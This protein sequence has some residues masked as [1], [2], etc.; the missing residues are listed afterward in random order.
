MNQELTFEIVP[1]DAGIAPAAKQSL[2]V[3]FSGFFVDAAKLE[4]K[5]A[6]ITDP[7]EARI[8]RLEVKNLRVAVE[9]KHKEIKADALLFGRAVDGAKNIFLA[10][11]QPIERAME[12]IEKAAERAAAEALERVRVERQAKLDE[13]GHDCLGIDLGS[14]TEAQWTAYLQQSK[15]AA[16]ARIEREAK[17]AA[18]LKAA[19]EAEAAAREAQRL[20][21]IRLREEAERREAEIA[22]E[23]AAAEKE[24]KRLEAEATAR[25]NAER[26]EW[27]K[28]EAK[29]KADREAAEEEARKER[30]A[31]AKDA[32]RI[33][34]ETNAAIMKAAKEKAKLEAEAQA[35]RDAAAAKAKAE[36]DAAMAKA[37]AEALAAKKAAAA[38][39]KAKLMHFADIVRHLD[40]PLAKSEDGQRV[41]AEI[42]AKCEN[43]AK[44]IEAQAATL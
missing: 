8:C 34:E 7:K 41:A 9:K 31:A 16:Q 10:K 25:L 4:E 38:P 39:D 21:N 29:A 32:A 2:E 20:E 19:Q 24:R 3:A 14:L 36:A 22:K 42:G 44:W 6:H 13:I 18:E 12:D 40:V 11:C 15:D 5:A 37:K 1:A 17:A 35:L 28:I 26:A 27:D 43:F 33:R 23:R 30:E